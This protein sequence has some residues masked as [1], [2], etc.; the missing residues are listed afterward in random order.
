M[1]RGIPMI[2][3]KEI[4]TAIYAL[5]F[6]DN[7]ILQMNADCFCDEFILVYQE[8]DVNIKLIFSA[9]VDIN[10]ETAIISKVKNNKLFPQRKLGE[11]HKN[12]LFYG[13]EIT[14]EML[15][16]NGCSSSYITETEFPGY[17]CEIQLQFGYVTL[18]CGHISVERIDRQS[19]EC[20]TILKSHS[21]EEMRL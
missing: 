11:T 3:A 4:E 2:K 8:E 12:I 18:H 20:T 1:E 17:C 19:G 9:S 16:L 21:D 14:D 7:E 6:D 13:I 15:Q 10:V 5:D